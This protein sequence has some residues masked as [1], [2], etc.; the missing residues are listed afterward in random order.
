MKKE[1]ASPSIKHTQYP[2]TLA[3]ASAF[4]KIQR[5]IDFDLQK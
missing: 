5:V 4:L 2:L 1:S 3:W